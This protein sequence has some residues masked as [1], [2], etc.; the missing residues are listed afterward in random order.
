M[1]RIATLLFLTLMLPSLPVSATHI[2]PGQVDGADLPDAPQPPE[3]GVIPV[4]QRLQRAA[5]DLNES[6]D[7]VEQQEKDVLAA[8]NDR[9]DVGA[10][11]LFDERFGGDRHGGFGDW[12]VLGDAAWKELAGAGS[13]GAGYTTG[14]KADGTYL[15]LASSALASPEID[16]RTGYEGTSPGGFDYLAL[17]DGLPVHP[18][19]SLYLGVVEKGEF[20]ATTYDESL[21]TL[22]GAGVPVPS[23]A[24]TV[25]G[26]VRTTVASRLQLVDDALAGVDVD[27]DVPRTGP[28]QLLFTVH[29]GLS[30]VNGDCYVFLSGCSLTNPGVQA[31][32]AAR[33]GATILQYEMRHN[34]AAGRDV[35]GILALAVPPTPEAIAHCH[36]LLQSGSL[37]VDPSDP[38]DEVRD[39][40]FVSP[41]ERDPTASQWDGYTGFSDWQIQSIDLTPWVGGSVWLV[42]VFES[43]STPGNYF[44]SVDFFS[45]EAGFYGFGLD[46][47]TLTTPGLPQSLRVR[48]VREPSDHPGDPALPLPTLAIDAPFDGAAD[49]VNMGLRESK[50]AARATLRLQ[51]D[52]VARAELGPVTLPPGSTWSVPFRFDGMTE[53]PARYDLEVALTPLARID[54]AAEADPSDD[55]Q[56][57]GVD[58]R[59]VTGWAAGDLERSATSVIKGQDAEF[60]LPLHNHGNVP[61]V[62][63]AQA[64]LIEVFG[65]RNGIAMADAEF[66]LAPEPV[67]TL[68]PGESRDLVWR[69]RGTE[70]GTF[71]LFARVDD[72]AT[73][74]PSSTFQVL[75]DLVPEEMQAR[76]VAEAASDPLVNGA[77]EAVEWGGA[78][79]TRMEWRDPTGFRAVGSLYS[80]PPGTD[81]ASVTGTLRTLANETHLFIGLEVPVPSNGKFRSISLLVDDGADGI[82]PGK[83]RGVSTRY[84]A[85]AAAPADEVTVGDYRFATLSRPTWDQSIVTQV[86]SGDTDLEDSLTELPG[87]ARV[88][89]L[90]Q[91]LDTPVGAVLDLD[92]SGTPTA[93]DYRL[94][95]SPGGNAPAINETHHVAADYGGFL[96]A[97]IGNVFL[98]KD[99]A[100]ALPVPC[101]RQGILYLA[102]TSVAS[103]TAT[104]DCTVGRDQPKAGIEAKHGDLRLQ[105]V[106]RP[107]VAVTDT[108]FGAGTGADLLPGKLR[109]H[110]ADGD[111]RFGPGDSLYVDMTPAEWNKT[112]GTPWRSA[113]TSTAAPNPLV[114]TAE[115]AIP[116][117]GAPGGLQAGPGDEVRLLAVA[118][119]ADASMFTSV[120]MASLRM[121]AGRPFLDGEGFT[122]ADGSRDDEAATWL[123][124]RLPTPA[125]GAVST[126]EQR[127]VSYGFGVDRSAPPLAEVEL[128]SC[129]AL[130]GWFQTGTL[131]PGYA[132]ST[133]DDSPRV[134]KWTCQPYGS[135]GKVRLF[136]GRAG[137]AC[138]SDPCQPTSYVGPLGQAPTQGSQREPSLLVSPPIKVPD[139]ILPYVLLRHQYSTAAA[140][141]DAL[142]NGRH[143]VSLR[144][145]AQVFVQRQ[146]PDGTW[147]AALTLVIPEA[148]LSSLASTGLQDLRFDRDIGLG[149]GLVPAPGEG[150]A[151]YTGAAPLCPGT[152][153]PL[154]N[155]VLSVRNC[156]WWW[157]TGEQGSWQQPVDDIPLGGTLAG[158]PWT[159]DRLPLF[160][161][162]HGF[163]GDQTLELGG[164]TIRLLLSWKTTDVQPDDDIGWRIEGLAITEG[165]NLAS[166]VGAMAIGLPPELAPLA[167]TGLAPGLPIPLVVSATNTGVLDAAGVRVQARA[168]DSV[169]GAEYCT[170][171]KEG[172]L[173]PAGAVLNVTVEC[174]PA[175]GTPPAAIVFSANVTLAAGRDDFPADNT[176][177]TPTPIRLVSRPDVAV[178]AEVSPKDS[179]RDEPRTLR[180]ALD[181]AGN[182]PLQ[183]LRV[184][185]R[186][187]RGA[188]QD[189]PEVWKRS[190]DLQGT[191]PVGAR[192]NLTDAAL[193]ADPDIQPGDLS[194]QMTGIDSQYQFVTKVV[195]AGDLDPTN[196]A[197]RQP[198]RG[199]DAT[200]ATTFDTLHPLA[201]MT[202]EGTPGVWR[203]TGN[204]GDG[205]QRLVAGDPDTGE[206]PLGADAWAILPMQDLR[207]LQGATL[208]FRQRF[209]LEEGFDAARVEVSTNGG[210]DWRPLRPVAQPLGG[211]PLGYSSAVLE[212]NDV[213]LDPFEAGGVA[214]TGSS[215]R[216]LGSR[217]GWVA[218]S[219]DLARDPGLS[220]EAALVAFSLEGMQSEPL[221]TPS[222]GADGV[223]VFTH[224]TWGEGGSVEDSWWV[225]DLTY[226]VPLPHSDGK[227]WWSGSAGE[228]SAEHPLNPVKDRLDRTLKFMAPSRPQ[229][230]VLATWW[231]WRAGGAEGGTGG[232]FSVLV[233]GVPATP[234]ELASEP[235][236]WRR[237]G[238]DVTDRRGQTFHLTFDYDSTL[239]TPYDQAKRANNHGWQIDDLQVA[240]FEKDRRGGL[241][242]PVVLVETDD[243]EDLAPDLFPASGGSSS[244]WTTSL[245]GAS[246]PASVGWSLVGAHASARGPA[247]HIEPV[248][249]P[250]R[251]QAQGWRFASA[252][253]Q[254]YPHGADTRLVT[255]LVDLDVPGGGELELRFD[256]RYWLESRLRC[257]V[258]AVVPATPDDK[259]AAGCFVDAIDAGAVEVQVRD[260]ATGAYG[261]WQQLAREPGAFP[262]RLLFEA[263]TDDCS[264]PTAHQA[265]ADTDPAS[266]PCM[267]HERSPDRLSS[268]GSSRS[269][270]EGTGYSALEF[271]GGMGIA[272]H[273]QCVFG[274]STPAFLPLGQGSSFQAFDGLTHYS[275]ENLFDKNGCGTTTLTGPELVLPWRESP[276]SYVF[277]GSSGGWNQAAWNITAFAG[278]QVRFAFH[279]FSD[280]S[281]QQNLADPPKDERGWSIA[282]VQVAGKVF[283]GKPTLLRFHV[284]TDDSLAKGEWSI[285][286][287]TI[288]GQS[289]TRNPAILP[290]DSTLLQVP[291]GEDVAFPIQLAN[292]GASQ[293]VGLVLGLIAADEAGAG[294][295][296]EDVE[297]DLEGLLALPSTQRPDGTHAAW[298]I[299]DLAPGQTVTGE[300]RVHLPGAPTEI[301]IHL[302]LFELTPNGYALARGD[303][304]GN[305]ALDLL[306]RGVT[307][308]DIQITAP[309]DAVGQALTVV[310]QGGVR[311]VKAIASNHGTTEPSLRAQ[312]SL[313]RVEHRGG[314]AQPPAPPIDLTAVQAPAAQTLGT[315]ARDGTLAIEAPLAIAAPGMY[316]V[317]LRLM[318]GEEVVAEAQQEFLAG[319]DGS[320]AAYDFVHGDAWQL[321][322]SDQSPPFE[323]GE[324]G[325][326]PSLRFRDAGDALLWGVTDEQYVAGTTYCTA[327]GAQCEVETA[328]G[329]PGNP[330]EMFTVRGLEGIAVGP[331]IDLTAVPQGQALLTLR[332]RQILEDGDGARVELMPVS[333]SG[334][335]P[336]AL[337]TCADGIQPMTFAPLP[338]PASE[339]GGGLANVPGRQVPALG[340]AN[341]QTRP[342]Q[343]IPNRIHPLAIDDARPGS[344]F[345]GEAPER[346]TRFSLGE[347][348]ASTCPGTDGNLVHLDVV[349]YIVQPVLRVGTRLGYYGTALAGDEDRRHG[350]MG[351]QVLGMRISST[352][353]SLDRE[354]RVLR[355]R[356]GLPKTFTMQFSNA[357]EV[358]DAYVAT[359]VAEDPADERG[360][361]E[362]PAQPIALTP[363]R[364][365]ELPLKV[366]IPT[367]PTLQRGDHAFRLTVQSATD[368]GVSDSLRLVLR[369][370]GNALP[371]LVV[372]AALE[373]THAPPQVPAGSQ[374]PVHVT[375]NNLGRLKAAPT[376]I[377]LEAVG[378]DGGRMVVDRATVPELC[379]R[380]VCGETGSRHV[381][382]LQWPV[383]ETPGQQRLEVRVD[384]DGRLLEENRVNNL[385][386]LDALAV[387]PELADVAITS[388]T[389][390]PAEEGKPLVEGDYVRLTATVA[391]LGIAP[392]GS[393][394]ATLYYDDVAVGD[395]TLPSLPAG[396][397]VELR[398]VTPVHQGEAIVRAT[399]IPLDGTPDLDD[400][401]ED[402]SITLRVHDQGLR[403]DLD[404]SNLTVAAGQ[405]AVLGAN[406]TN[407]G[408]G[409]D[410]VLVRLEAPRGWS[411][412]VLPNPVIAPPNSTLPLR[413]EVAAPD[414]APAGN[415]TLRITASPVSNPAVRVVTP[416]VAH[417]PARVGA[418]SLSVGSASAPP[419]PVRLG[420]ELA[421]TANLAQDLTLRV[422]SPGNWSAQAETVRLPAGAHR[423]AELVLVVPPATPPGNVT[424]AVEALDASGAV[425]ATEPATVTVL[426]D[427][428]A[429]AAWQSVRAKPSP[430]GVRDTEYVLAVNNTGNVPLLARL[431]LD[432]LEQGATVVSQS[433]AT[434]VAVGATKA[435]AIVVRTNGTLP[436]AFGR[437][438]V[439]AQD[440]G[441]NG[442]RALAPLALPGLDAGPDLA[443]T[444][445]EVLAAPQVGRAGRF[446]VEVRNVGQL[447]AP[448]TKLFASANGDLVDVL[449]VPPIPAGGSAVLNV[450]WTFDEPG[451]YAL[452]FIADG[453][454]ALA[455]PH[456]DDNGRALDLSVDDG[457]L[458][459]Q[460]RSVPAPSWLMLVGLAL[461]LAGLLRRRRA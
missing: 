461:A 135:D 118:E 196:D 306:A 197:L 158:S 265:W 176:L 230:T 4:D 16:L 313:W 45:L 409:V 112:A 24:N 257:P 407:L 358:P 388:L 354:E 99:S 43:Q 175:A 129:T 204:S 367:D 216:L 333:L 78:E 274:L 379:A 312:W 445:V 374:Q 401:N 301:G 143:E 144:G 40:S 221:A 277:S 210:A 300:V 350:A 70:A 272:T 323:P 141:N 53:E 246:S 224:P 105:N 410:P 381:L 343:A 370:Q 11:R 439:L 169:T 455:E 303:A 307:H 454:D 150:G 81:S 148:G 69:V 103:P 418:P 250:G 17:M 207:P 22:R 334:P 113:V 280:P 123:A 432:G 167:A 437:V 74:D 36:A 71:R 364:R 346:T 126:H 290:L 360:W 402:V 448:A 106:T 44:R 329:S 226:D 441:G 227:M 93:G 98:A 180:I 116:F 395:R 365:G 115:F 20:A 376:D 137:G 324:G 285:D 428:Q 190:W 340:P 42:W 238:V 271:R 205:S 373:D 189:A 165:R 34:L 41:L 253:Q 156:A 97:D 111:G 220:R 132:S 261:P 327:P 119:F 147:A 378:A 251:G 460:L 404:T 241:A 60:R 281:Y 133:W 198:F 203:V 59:N 223:G 385:A 162:G 296:F 46:N 39:C 15:G 188:G 145:G 332:H 347:P 351:W 9:P 249:V 297:V 96:E 85:L 117:A 152:Y 67:F 57:T 214:F 278:K 308:T 459:G 27:L 435:M 12:T 49:I 450:T 146:L 89:W 173:L 184:E 92:E 108:D 215:E 124:L 163:G 140:V 177:L 377:V 58:V 405:A 172:L 391:N 79:A 424:V 325:S 247:W 229:D 127:R 153:Q 6:I 139:G 326:P 283:Q 18:P 234:R 64:Q 451:R 330:P 201:G 131:A 363:G 383:P 154:I 338:D 10:L 88:L 219:F 309:D 194:F 7:V 178:V 371:D 23:Q 304:A 314:P 187:L 125:T 14:S 13:A 82:Q 339:Y 77:I 352:G 443:V 254:G 225:D 315:L 61:A 191:L 50:V 317:R 200:Y 68:A 264:L 47:V 193:D 286:N 452:A 159:V 109:F 357:G 72:A 65:P 101:V 83:D 449:D 151:Q 38:L 400:S 337:L 305:L 336:R 8:L 174:V 245:L 348:L 110:D 259:R 212:G 434:N 86:G 121:P 138:P 341:A 248:E 95:W 51:G 267:A 232:S 440:A 398:A 266:G 411:L 446:A 423:Q 54:A 260:G 269:L 3:T 384:P 161:P 128:S 396:E 182:V 414:D 369:L 222:V 25:S 186:V 206:I 255:P 102:L 242:N 422:R 28:S 258:D 393:M 273:G 231:D 298:R 447:P 362:L 217:A 32:V 431:A 361:I 195:L 302:A 1:N 199:L 345:V 66:T 368:P 356:D 236:G 179:T 320:Y 5:S 155:T 419:G 295:P 284:A 73:F 55:M 80:I 75:R 244:G 282:N 412:S 420:V 426:R 442:T 233:D 252:N 237:L 359:V 168:L 429:A 299:G 33:D 142:P 48:P 366:D 311:T 134:D 291:P 19:E 270:A 417:V 293:Q 268:A 240:S 63:K 26:V 37:P 406:L 392:A 29:Q 107:F 322:W 287:V 185:A 262:G 310:E 56:S 243:L 319:S 62:L 453:D 421:S 52:E 335:T 438:V 100:L 104:S 289:Y 87:A 331:P 425:V 386:P 256:H 130:D 427:P 170:G 294:Q 394:L 413:L 263:M 458:S 382:D 353:V 181:N 408:D 211:L 436:A 84:G 288:V 389:A 208:T 456:D 183:G 228:H 157:P 120:R 192:Q 149:E 321:G 430:L 342:A 171:V 375:V 397:S 213:F 328:V 218:T 349:G 90:E 372:S 94:A 76:Q 166:D 344:A 387:V 355:V 209:D 444:A 30:F 292:L 380:R 2:D 403:L 202:L 160:G 21:A 279:A 35:V 416:F 239:A 457:G 91:P 433:N 390:V 275:F 114:V 316:R 235:S 31:D 164:Q 415:L 399:V 276:V 136:E 122:P 318:D